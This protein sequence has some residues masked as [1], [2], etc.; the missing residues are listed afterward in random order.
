MVV[1]SDGPDGTLCGEATD[2]GIPTV[3]VEMGEV[4]FIG[5]LIGLP[6]NPVVYPGNP[7]CHLVEIGESTRRAIE[8][9][10]APTPVGQPAPTD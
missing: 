4:P 6:E 7:L 2:D 1:D 8:A 9:G 5:L 10:D 3:T